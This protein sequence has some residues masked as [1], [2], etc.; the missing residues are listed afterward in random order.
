MR[1]RSRRLPSAVS[2]RVAPASTHSF[3]AR[4]RTTTR[5]RPSSSLV[6]RGP[7]PGWV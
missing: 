1:L 4:S 5:R 7:S 2:S 6:R 3:W